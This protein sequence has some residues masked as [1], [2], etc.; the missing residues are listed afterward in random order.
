MSILFVTAHDLRSKR[1]A[2]V[3]FITEEL[4]RR[5]PVR[6]FSA[7]FSYLSRIRARDPRLGLE[8]CANRIE[9]AGNTESFLWFTPVHPGNAGFGGNGG[10]GR[11]AFGLYEQ[12]APAVLWRWAAEA[13]LIFIESGIGLAFVKK[14]RKAAPDAK[15]IYIASDDLE[16]IGVHSVLRDALRETSHLI[17]GYR[18]PARALL[19]SMPDPAKCFYVPHGV[20]VKRFEE[21]GAD[22]Y[23]T[24]EGP[25]AV[26]VGSMLFD[27]DFFWRAVDIMPAAQ[28][29]VIGSG[30]PK[31]KLPPSVQYHPEMPFSDTLAFLQHAS[32]GIAAYGGNKLPYYIA[33]S[34]MKLMQYDYLG[35]PSLCPDV[36]V[37]EFG[38]L[39]CGYEPGNTTSIVKALSRVMTTPRGR[40]RE[41]LTWADVV[42]RLINPS[43][44]SDTSILQ[45]V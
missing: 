40:R 24:S 41:F 31:N 45:G 3:H 27:A 33:E 44:F 5:F 14:L 35:L 11:K 32:F 16:T 43:S 12:F 25:K 8:H 13:T 22:P 34:S 21:L 4:S 6:V 29:H 9:R 1:K 20:D 30:I 15:I 37:G 2:N 36:A 19:K 10:L 23:Q 17:D 38:E 28:I 42:D 18:L 26:S 39:R 7:G